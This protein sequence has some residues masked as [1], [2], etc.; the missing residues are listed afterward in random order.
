M[1]LTVWERTVSYE[2]TPKMKKQEE[3]KGW[4]NSLVS[5]WVGAGKRQIHWHTVYAQ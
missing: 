3:G 5:A 2:E 1:K 4:V